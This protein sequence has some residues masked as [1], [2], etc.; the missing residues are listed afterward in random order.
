MAYVIIR[1]TI[2]IYYIHYEILLISILIQNFKFPTHE[3]CVQQYRY[4]DVPA[5]TNQQ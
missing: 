5:V 3:L 4:N 2:S 1:I